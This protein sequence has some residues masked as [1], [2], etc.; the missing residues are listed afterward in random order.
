MVDYS[1][2]Q[3]P[4]DLF[5]RFPEKCGRVLE[6][7]VKD[8]R[9]LI[10][11]KASNDELSDFIDREFLFGSWGCESKKLPSKMLNDIRGFIINM[12]KM[13]KE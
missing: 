9:K 6:D 3:T 11:K 7:L 8:L 10:D 2:K 12:Y 4:K 1:K 13:E 5:E